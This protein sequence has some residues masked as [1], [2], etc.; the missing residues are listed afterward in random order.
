M[1]RHGTK[2]VHRGRVTVRER[3]RAPLFSGVQR[4]GG[5]AVTGVMVVAAGTIPTMAW[6]FIGQAAAAD[7]LSQPTPAVTIPG[8][9]P[10]PL[11]DEHALPNGGTAYVFKQVD[12]NLV[13]APVPPSGFRPSTATDAQLAEYDFPARPPAGAPGLTEWEQLMA[14]YRQPPIPSFCNLPTVSAATPN[15]HWSGYVATQSSSPFVDAWGNY[16]QQG[17]TANCSGAQEVSWVGIGGWGGSTSLIQAGTGKTGSGYVAW[18]EYLDS[19]YDSHI[20]AYTGSQLHSGDPIHIFISYSTANQ[21]VNLD[22]FDNGTEYAFNQHLDPAFYDG[23][24]AEW[25]DERPEVGGAFTP[26]ADFGTNPWSNG[27]VLTNGGSQLSIGQNSNLEVKMTSDGT[28]NGTILAAPGGL[29][30]SGTS[31]NDTWDHC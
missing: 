3:D 30:S 10:L 29:G 20:T 1:T 7:A 16:T 25:I 24:S 27:Y 5:S 26:L 17:I 19:T 15:S 14:S 13:T 9:N 23:S 28:V 6:A 8:C 18:Y 2:V 4:P 11:V 31:F 21:Q 12:G 22:V